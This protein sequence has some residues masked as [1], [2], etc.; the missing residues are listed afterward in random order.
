MQNLLVVER[1]TQEPEKDDIIKYV[2]EIVDES[3]DNSSV[4]VFKNLKILLLMKFVY[5]RTKLQVDD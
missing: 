2:T 5:M 1:F 3:L 4:K